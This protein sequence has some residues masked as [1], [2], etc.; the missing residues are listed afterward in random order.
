MLASGRLVWFVTLVA[1]LALGTWAF[2]WGAVVVVS[3]AW[4]WI[5]RADGAV[6][7]LSAV[8]GISAWAALLGLQSLQGPVARVAAVVGAAMQVGAG[9]LVLLTLAFPALLAGATAGVVRGLASER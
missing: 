9:P 8:A 5:R 7:L 2:G 1:A 4:A 3:G 6:T